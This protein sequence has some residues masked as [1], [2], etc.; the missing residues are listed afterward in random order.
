MEDKN[1]NTK[2]YEVSYSQVLQKK[3]NKLLIALI[4]LVLALILGLA[5]TLIRIDMLNIPSRIIYGG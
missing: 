1:G 5:F 4:V 3:A 2:H